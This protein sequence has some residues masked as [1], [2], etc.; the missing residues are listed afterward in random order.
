MT[1]YQKLEEALLKG[2]EFYIHTPTFDLFSY[3]INLLK[4]NEFR[5]YVPGIKFDLYDY[6]MWSTY[7]ENTY[8]FYWKN[9]TFAYGGKNS[10]N[11]RDRYF[12]NLFNTK[13]EI[14]EH[15]YTISIGEYSGK[16]IIPKE[17]LQLLK[18]GI[19]IKIV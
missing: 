18:E 4:R 10:I 13:E 8:L 19:K 17:A 12:L 5:S 9:D 15:T 6:D 16:L 1:V 7:E 2:E 3:I 14:I 11:K